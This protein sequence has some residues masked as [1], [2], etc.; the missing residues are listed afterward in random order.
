MPKACKHHKIEYDPL[1]VTEYCQ[2]WEK[3]QM[4]HGSSGGDLTGGQNGDLLLLD[5]QAQYEDYKK[6]YTHNGSWSAAGCSVD[7]SSFPAVNDAMF[8]VDR[9]NDADSAVL[10]ASSQA[11]SANLTRR[12]TFE[13]GTQHRCLSSTA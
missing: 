10:V 12:F 6:C 2:P 1:P 4:G 5:S 7:I 8:D 13:D 11:F 9:S 3:C